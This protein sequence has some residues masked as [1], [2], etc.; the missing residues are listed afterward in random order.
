MKKNALVL[1]VLLLASVAVT[2]FAVWMVAS[3]LEKRVERPEVPPPGSG[4]P[5]AAERDDPLHLRTDPASLITIGTPQ[6]AREKR[7]ALVAAIWKDRGFPHAKRPRRVERAVGDTPW[8]GLAGLDR[9]DRITVRMEY[10]LVSVL[11]LF[12]PVEERGGPVVYCEGHE[13]D[14]R[15]GDVEFFLERGHPVLAV[16]MP[17]LGPNN[18]PVV[19]FPGLGVIRMETHEHLALLESDDFSPIAYFVEP[20]AV[21]LNHLEKERH[22]GPVS[23]VGLSG[24]AWVIALYAALDPRV[25]HSYPVAGTLPLYLRSVRTSDQGDWEQRLAGLHRTA[26]CLDWYVLGAWGEGRRQMQVFN[27]DD[28]CCFAGVRSLLYRDQVEA[29]VER[30][31]SGSFEVFLDDSHAD[32]RISTVVLERIA[33]EIAPVPE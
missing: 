31:G 2:V 3:R 25:S 5:A 32:H 26:G 15:T 21:G 22:R 11:Y 30:L 18:Q 20:V 19:V 1:L 13:N 28:P 14:L 17:L 7:A 23:M 16:W 29:A 4:A 12:H 10:G 9:I 27:R 33:A 24:G 8:S 6:Q